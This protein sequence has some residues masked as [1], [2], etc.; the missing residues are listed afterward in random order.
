MNS[1]GSAARENEAYLNSIE[2]K[3]KLLTTDLQNMWNNAINSDFLK[4]LIDVGDQLIK[5][6]DS[7]GLIPSLLGATTFGYTAFKKFNLFDGKEGKGFSL[8]SSNLLSEFDNKGSLAEQEE[9]ANSLKESD[10]SISKYLLGL[11][12]AKKKQQEMAQGA[13]DAGDVIQNATSDVASNALEQASRQT[14]DEMQHIAD[15]A[16]AASGGLKEYVKQTV[17]A[18]AR[19]FALQAVSSLAFSALS[20]GVSWLISAGMS[21]IIKFSKRT[22]TAID[23]ARAAVD[24]FGE[25][26]STLKKQKQ[27]TEELAASYRK[28]S[29]GVD[30]L[31]NAN[32]GLSVENYNEY[33]N[34]CNQIADLYPELVSGYDSQGNAIV[35]LTNNVDRLTDAYHSAEEAAKSNLWNGTDEEGNLNRKNVWT[36]YNE[37]ILKGTQRFFKA[38]T[39]SL[40]QQ[41]NLI[42]EILQLDTTDLKKLYDEINNPDS[43][44]TAGQTV[45]NWYH[46]LENVSDDLKIEKSEAVEQM[47]RDYG[48][49][50]RN[51]WQTFLNSFKSAGASVESQISTVM[52]DMRTTILSSMIFNDGYQQL[53]DGMKS[54]VDNFINNLSPEDIA[55]LGADTIEAVPQKIIEQLNN[56][57]VKKE[58][59]DIFNDIESSLATAMG[60]KNKQAFENSYNDLQE[61]VK[62]QNWKIG[63]DGLIEISENDDFVTSYLKNLANQLE[64]KSK[65]FSVKL[66]FQEDVDSGKNIQDVFSGADKATQKQVE[67]IEKAYGNLDVKSI[68][69]KL[70]KDLAGDDGE[71]LSTELTNLYDDWVEAGMPDAPNENWTQPQINGLQALDAMI[72]LYGT[73][74]N[75]V[76]QQLIDFGMVTPDGEDLKVKPTNISALTAEQENYKAVVKASNEVLY[77]GQA[78]SDDYYSSISEYIGDVAELTACFDNSNGHIVKN[79]A[80]LKELIDARK[81]ETLA[82]VSEAKAQSQLEYIELTNEL[83]NQIAALDNATNAQDENTQKKYDDIAALMDQI[84]TIRTA[85]EQYE[86]LELSLMG[87]TDAFDKFNQAKEID[88]AADYTTQF[89]EMI[90]A[91]GE[92]FDTGKIGTE[93]FR[94]AVKGLMDPKIYGSLSTPEEMMRVQKEFNSGNLSKFF[95]FDDNTYKVT[96]KNLENFVAAAQK[97]GVMT[98]D[99]FEEFNIK[100]GTSLAEFAEALHISEGAVYALMTEV[101]KHNG[102]PESLLSQFDDLKNVEGYKNAL[103]EAS[104]AE[105]NLLR[106]RKEGKSVNSENKE[107]AKEYAAAVQTAAEAQQK[108]IDETKN[109]A[110]ST[111]AQ[112]AVN[113]LYT[114]SVEFQDTGLISLSQDRIDELANTL[115]QIDGT[116]YTI[117]LQDGTITDAEGNTQSLYDKLTELGGAPIEANV[118]MN[119]QGLLEQ[120]EHFK[121]EKETLEKSIENSKQLGLD[122]SDA[123]AKLADLDST[124]STL[125]TAADTL[126]LVYNITP[127]AGE[128]EAQTTIEQLKAYEAEG[129]N[130]PMSADTTEAAAAVNAFRAEAEAP[131]STTLTVNIVE[132]NSVVTPTAQP[133]T[134]QFSLNTGSYDTVMTALNAVSTRCSVTDTKN[135]EVT[136]NGTAKK[137][138]DQLDNIAKTKLK[139]KEFTVK[140]SGAPAVTSA[141]QSIKSL[142]DGIKDKNISV[143]TN[144]SSTG[145]PPDVGPGSHGRRTGSGNVVNGTAH[146]QGTAK[147]SGSWGAQATVTALT[148][149]LGQELVVRGDRW[150]TVGDNG[151][152]FTDI[153]KGDIIFNH[154]QTESLFKNGYV[155]GRGKAYAQGTSNSIPGRTIPEQPLKATLSSNVFGKWMQR[156]FDKGNVSIDLTARPKIDATDMVEAGWKELDGENSTSTVYSSSFSN[157]D[158]TKTVVVTPILPNGEVLSPNELSN[159]AGQLLNG[160]QIDANIELATFNGEDSITQAGKYCQ[161]LHEVQA[162]YDILEEE[163]IENSIGKGL[164]N[165]TEEISGILADLTTNFSQFNDTSAEPEL[166][167]KIANLQQLLEDEGYTDGAIDNIF[168]VLAEHIQGTSFAESVKQDLSDAS[169]SIENTKA[170]LDDFGIAYNEIQNT[171]GSIQ[172]NVDEHGLYSLWTLLGT[173]DQ[174]IAEMQAKWSENGIIITSTFDSSGSD[175]ANMAM[176]SIHSTVS[177]I[178]RSIFDKLGIT[179]A[180]NNLTGIDGDSATVTVDAQDNTGGVIASIKAKFNGLMSTLG[181]GG[182]S[183]VNGTAHASGNWGLKNDEH[184]ALVGELGTELVVNPYTGTY[185]TV[186]ENG[187]EFVDLPKGSIIFN[188]KQTEDLLQHG[189][190][191]SRG[192][193][194]ADGNAHVLGNAY[195]WTV[196]TNNSHTNKGSG[197]S[198][199]TSNKNSSNKDKTTKTKPKTSKSVED[200]AKDTAEEIVDFIEFKLEEIEAVISKTSAKLETYLDNTMNAAKKNSAYDELVK[201]EQNKAK[202]YL[203]AAEAYN[204]KATE[205]LSKVPDEYKDMAK[206]G[207]INIK[208]FVGESEGKIAEAINNYREWAKKAD[209][210]EAG[211]YEALQQQ[212]QYRLDQI[213]DIADDYDNLIKLIDGRKDRIEAHIDLVETSGNRVGSEYYTS[214]IKETED[215]LKKQ[216]DKRKA[217][218]DQLATMPKGTDAWYEAKELLNEVDL[219]ILE[220]KNDIEDYKNSIN[221]LHWDNFDK[222]LSRFEAIDSELGNIYDRFTD[223]EDDIADESGNWNSKG[224]AAIGIAAQQMESAQVKAKQYKKEIAYLNAA[225]KKG[226]YST[227]EYNEKLAELK[228]GYWECINSSED[229]KDAIIDLNKTRIE[230][231]K[232]GIDKEI[233]ANEKLIDSFK[234]MIDK[235]KELLDAEKESYDFEKSVNEQQKEIATIER[236]LAAISGNTS[237]E[238]AAKR[239]ALKA[240]LAEAQVKM[241]DILYNHSIEKQKEALD[242]QYEIYEDDIKNKNDSLEDKKESLDE[243]LKEEEKLIK[244]SIN[245][246]KDNADVVLKEIDNLAKQYGIEISEA[247]RSPWEDGSNAI[248]SFKNN[249]KDLTDSFDSYLDKIIDQENKL[250][251]AAEETAKKV[252]ISMD[253]EK[254]GDAMDNAFAGLQDKLQ[255]KEPSNGGNNQSGGSSGTGKTPKVNDKVTVDQDAGTYGGSASNVK[256]PSW[257]K[258]KTYTVQQINAKKQEALLKEINSWVKISDLKGYAKGTTGVD[259]DQFAWLHELGEEL[260]LHAGKDGKLAYMTKGTAV[261]P[262][263]LT[264]R[265]MDLAVDPTTA[266]EQS[267]PVISAPHIV[268]NEINIDAS[269]AEVIHIDSVNNDTLPNLEKVVNRQ[270]DKYMRGINNQIRKYTR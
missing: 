144:Y 94:A 214:L 222:L 137:V 216:Q 203:Q 79:A 110:N 213:N 237:I 65:N 99:S 15:G 141:L 92:G 234:E 195:A 6:V 56:S 202:T 224:L 135:V 210:A 190:V 127:G 105:E 37:K 126:E 225:Y 107:D 28:L 253:V 227:D 245:S 215:A 146:A 43:L 187:A 46:D 116:T 22:E 21:A 184:N 129:I 11:V 160:E 182:G 185:Y 87:A 168:G 211:Y 217:I 140:M 98:G 25:E 71:L 115:G 57:N 243:S 113:E 102:D 91:I 1:A 34:V 157:E 121:S 269:I 256:I 108:V 131:M 4:F 2:G 248:S 18:T 265:L 59:L 133:K 176:S 156:Q 67:K 112:G 35:N 162:I 52:Q 219:A 200:T 33:L 89:E 83:N 84:D 106:L 20:A 154:K 194:L 260:V 145:T 138:Q 171:D 122:T 235:R 244:D 109:M 174:E 148:G 62:S 167:V 7:F 68:S 238:A 45:W 246:V 9:F 254:V 117:N 72:N 229:A 266:L 50:A 169:S 118:Q 206:N 172:L 155:T 61:F 199:S 130:V 197:S 186:G 191:T 209:D 251:D 204:K 23:N 30:T 181:I 196:N 32:L 78:I 241:D 270:M 207:A 161:A 261:I 192:K 264:E 218:L 41:K 119:Y 53:D 101:E 208:D 163:D 120:I 3:I 95:T 55:K 173:T 5:L 132:S 201:A 193:M 17:V 136:D 170:L 75:T 64:N 96:R 267:R 151:A 103:K 232:K 31:T 205:L 86:M 66:K 44:N 252:A 228:E 158:G 40:A 247:I 10:K 268:N 125:Q 179:Q 198:S 255:G 220:C 240:E 97:A 143:K 180:Q 175:Q 26:Q 54:L 51:G 76:K 49:D 233:E 111:A 36:E 39:A 80:K 164:S 128:E 259:K 183:N 69:E 12:D 38:D 58:S 63:E 104:D 47:F 262:H 177:T 88:T 74:I 147:A 166:K 42:D 231:I 189:Y 188:H 242:K 142:L 178:I 29:G 81:Q 27:T 152:E 159:Y 19:T 139:N 114:A 82:T 77:E 150:F 90:G 226:E 230:A 221:D 85:I 93:T 249:F 48:I 212:T 124:I 16:R 100:A 70:V 8:K 73:D 223:N 165:R 239:A 236:K 24:K 14:G 263:D 257:V 13:Q 60:D 258:G 149:E 250:A 123:E 153:K 134:V